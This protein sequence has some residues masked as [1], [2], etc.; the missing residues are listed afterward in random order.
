MVVRWR[1]RVFV[2]VPLTALTVG[3]EDK[4][5]NEGE[6]RKQEKEEQEMRMW[7]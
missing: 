6:K 7:R 5:E 3:S 4:D 1:K 2:L